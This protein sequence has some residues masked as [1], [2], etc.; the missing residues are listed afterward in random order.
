VIGEALAILAG[1]RGA[2]VLDFGVS[3]ASAWEV[4]LACG[5]KIE[6]F[7]E[8][9]RRPVLDALRAARAAAQPVVLATPL[10]GAEPSV[11]A[12]DTSALALADVLRRDQAIVVTEGAHEV[13]LEPH[14]PPLRLVIIGAVHVAQPLAEMARLAGFAVTIVDPRRAWAAPA[15]FPGL[16]LVTD[17][18]DAAIAALRL[19]ARSAVVALTHDPKLDDPALIAAL[20]GPAFYL[21]CLGSTRTHAA[22]RARLAAIGL[23]AAALDRLHGP[24]GLRIGARSPAE[25]AVSILAEI[26]AALRGSA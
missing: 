1:E 15:R 13:L 10:D 11:R 26:I 8:A 18:P 9:A 20:G 19:D 3:D 14:N 16:A 5:G 25:I 6:V 22:R 21:G 2:G 24:V 17:W 4:G 23:D 12:A 7:V